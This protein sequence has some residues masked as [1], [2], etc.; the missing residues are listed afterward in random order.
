MGPISRPLLVPLLL[1]CSFAIAGVFSQANADPRRPP[2]IIEHIGNFFYNIANTLERSDIP[3]RPAYGRIRENPDRARQREL[4]KKP[5]SGVIYDN[6]G[7]IAP[8]NPDPMLLRPRTAVP[9]KLPDVSTDRSYLGPRSTPA[10]PVPKTT[11]PLPDSD[12]TKKDVEKPDLS[13]AKTEGR[14]A[15]SEATEKGDYPLAIPTNRMGRVKSPYPPHT[16]LDVA[17]LPPGSL[18]KDPVTGKIFRLH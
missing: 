18:A 10:P 15:S 14:G 3:E 7:Y 1:S 16:E 9:E 8:V 11:A 2:R 13:K 4:V 12:S 5:E 17:G 6:Q